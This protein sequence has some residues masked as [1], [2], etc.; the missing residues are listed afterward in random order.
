MQSSRTMVWWYSF[1]PPLHRIKTG[2]SEVKIVK[3]RKKLIHKVESSNLKIVLTDKINTDI[4]NVML[5][6]FIS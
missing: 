5:R 2:F 4:S 1:V 3:K 6:I